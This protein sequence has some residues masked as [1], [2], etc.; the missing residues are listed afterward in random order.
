MQDVELGVEVLAV[1]DGVARAHEGVGDGEG[2]GGGGH[3]LE[4]GARA[5]A[6]GLDLG[7]E[8]AEAQAAQ[9]GGHQEQAAA[10]EH[11]GVVARVHVALDLGPGA[12][13]PLGFGGRS[14]EFTV[15]S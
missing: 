11:V 12:G 2:G 5:V 13:R 8:Q 1:A 10:P 4:Q 14:G 9:G 3:H 15:S 6:R 7:G